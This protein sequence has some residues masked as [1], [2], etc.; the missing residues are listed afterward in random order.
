MTLGQMG[1]THLLKRTFLHM[2]ANYLQIE[3][4]LFSIVPKE[5]LSDYFSKLKLNIKS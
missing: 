5:E 3:K 4:T 1:S 2:Q